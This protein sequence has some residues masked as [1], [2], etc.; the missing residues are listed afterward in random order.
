MFWEMLFL[1]WVPSKFYLGSRGNWYS[2]HFIGLRRRSRI[3]FGYFFYGQDSKMIMYRQRWHTGHLLSQ[4]KLGVTSSSAVQTSH[5]L[6][7]AMSS[8]AKASWAKA[9]RSSKSM[10]QMSKCLGQSVCRCPDCPQRKHTI[11]TEPVVHAGVVALARD[12]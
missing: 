10:Y 12:G 3:R 11:I 8:T 4:P 7:S 2:F 1:F 6:A 5:S 9:C